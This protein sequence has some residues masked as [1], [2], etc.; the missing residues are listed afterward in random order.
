MQCMEAH[1]AAEGWYE[2]IALVQQVIK[3]V[4]MCLC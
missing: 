3:D 1:L 4:W 2:Y